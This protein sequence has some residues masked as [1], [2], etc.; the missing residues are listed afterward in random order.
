MPRNFI[1]FV[2]WA[3][4]EELRSFP[5]TKF[6]FYFFLHLESCKVPNIENS[7]KLFSYAYIDVHSIDK[8]IFITK[9]I[10]D[11][12]NTGKE[13]RK[14]GKHHYFARRPIFLSEICSLG[15]YLS[16]LGKKLIAFF[17][18]KKLWS[19]TLWYNEDC[20]IL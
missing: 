1:K 19:S 2:L 7:R 5:L 15:K 10:K 16:Y 14:M 11:I 13:S 3:A 12:E 20:S 4:T 6:I 8:A 17:V 18:N 9:E